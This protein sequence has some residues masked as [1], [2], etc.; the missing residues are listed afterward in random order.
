MR[1][2][3]W[4]TEKFRDKVLNPV[5]LRVRTRV[6]YFD[7]KLD[8]SGRSVW[9]DARRRIRGSPLAEA[10]DWLSFMIDLAVDFRVRQRGRRT[11]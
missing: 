3:E 8:W 7:N 4:L 6:S 1:P 10:H 11:P 5:E 2:G 9:V